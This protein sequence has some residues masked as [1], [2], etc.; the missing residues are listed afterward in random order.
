[1]ATRPRLLAATS[2]DPEPANGSAMIPGGDLLTRCSMR[3][4]GLGVGCPNILG[5]CARCSVVVMT[6]GDGGPSHP[7]PMRYISSSFG[8]IGAGDTPG[9]RPFLCQMS[10]WVMFWG[11][12]FFHVPNTIAGLPSQRSRTSSLTSVFSS[13]TIDCTDD[14]RKDLRECNAPAGHA[15]PYG[16]SVMST[17]ALSHSVA[18]KQ[19]PCH[20]V[21]NSSW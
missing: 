15:T 10:L 16:G 11:R 14:S 4:T 2:V 3:P 12:G 18:S 8:K 21:T 20:S 6:V 5:C 7:P 17:S 19:S 9:C 1:M 13:P